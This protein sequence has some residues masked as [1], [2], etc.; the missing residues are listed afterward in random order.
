MDIQEFL[1]L[2]V[3]MS[4]YSSSVRRP[5]PFTLALQLGHLRVRRR[6]TLWL[7]SLR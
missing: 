4:P 5:V 2:G 7:W 6:R 3:D 1:L